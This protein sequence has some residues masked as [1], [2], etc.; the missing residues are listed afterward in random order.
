M[1]ESHENKQLIIKKVK[2]VKHGG[3]HGGAWKLAYADFVTA[4]MAFFLLLWLLSLLN[5]YQ[6]SGVGEYFKKP[7]KD[8]FNKSE[9]IKPQN[10]KHLIG[11]VEKS[12][13]KKTGDKTAVNMEKKLSKDGQHLKDHQNKEEQKEKEKE[14][15]MEVSQLAAVKNEIEKKITSTASLKEFKNQL[16]VQVTKQGLKITLKDLENNS[17]FPKGESD[18]VSK[19]N[20]IFPLISSEIGKYK[21]KILIKG[22][23]DSDQY[24]DKI[25]YTNWELSSDRANATRRALLKFGTP[26]DRFLRV[27]GMADV[28]PLDKNDSHSAINRRIEIIV[29]TDKAAQE[30]INE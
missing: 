1:S 12:G 7:L 5:K 14:K 27:E 26:N 23:T 29:L 20:K 24:Q 2:K 10:S 21:N 16:D 28:D 4:M 18:F 11:T 19:A 6:L 9:K 8:A 15:N 25:N 17:M 3:H 13:D 30:L 22:H